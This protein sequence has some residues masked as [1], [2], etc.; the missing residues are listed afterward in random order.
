MNTAYTRNY[1]SQLNSM[2]VGEERDITSPRYPGFHWA[3]RD[4]QT[5]WRFG[6]DWAYTKWTKTQ[7]ACLMT[8]WDIESTIVDTTEQ[9]RKFAVKTKAMKKGRK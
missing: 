3:I 5:E 1:L 6:D 8:R 9:I 7:A 2:K 4:S